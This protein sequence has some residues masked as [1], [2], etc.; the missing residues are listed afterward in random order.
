[1]TE[2]LV[3]EAAI[4][5]DVIERTV[6]FEVAGSQLVGILC[7]PSQGTPQRSV[8]FTHGWSG[9]RNGPAGLLTTLSRALAAKGC[10]CLRFDFRGRGESEGDG[11][12]ATLATMSEDLVA[13]T[14]KLQQLTGAKTVTLFG[15]CSGGNVAIGSLKRLPQADSMIMLSVYPFSDGDSFGRD[16]HRIWHFLGIYLKKA[17]SI[18]SWKR[19]FT[20]DASLKRVCQVIFKP[21]LKRGESKRHEEGSTPQQPQAKTVKASN[22]ESRLQPGQEPPKKYLANLRPDLRGLMIYGTADPDASAALKY[23]QVHAE[24]EKLPIQ[25]ETIEG[26]NHNF[27]SSI[28]QHRLIQLACDFIHH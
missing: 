17:C 22:H 4:Q 5:A 6:T 2:R 19:L 11:L 25:F 12:Q 21:L 20:G 26:A 28:W 7:L 14:Q 24:R 8:V 18:Q 15:M 9:N 1:M 16:M 27:S 13:A 3:Q 23:Y 10:A